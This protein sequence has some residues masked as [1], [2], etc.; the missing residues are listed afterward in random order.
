MRNYAQE[1]SIR[2]GI[3][4]YRCRTPGKGLWHQDYDGSRDGSNAGLGRADKG[5]CRGPARGRRYCHA[6][7]DGSEC[8]EQQTTDQAGGGYRINRK[9]PI[10]RIRRNS[11]R[12]R[13]SKRLS[14]AR[15]TMLP[16]RRMTPRRPSLPSLLNPPS[17]RQRP[18]S[19][20]RSTTPPSRTRVRLLR[21]RPKR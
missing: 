10:S 2:A 11:L 18:I 21:S 7:F 16:L 17:R 5:D 19:P 20:S 8:V 13:P 4:R 1:R 9:R 6:R 14:P 12:R 15:R 3:E